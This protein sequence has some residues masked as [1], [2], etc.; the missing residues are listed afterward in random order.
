MFRRT[1]AVITILAAVLCFAVK[2]DAAGKNDNWLVYW[3]ICGADNLEG[4]AHFST[5]NISEL[6]EVNMPPNVRVLLLAGGT[7]VWNHPT[8]KEKGDGIYLYSANGL[9]KLADLEADM[10]NPDTLAQFLKYGE[11]NFPADHRILIFQD[12]GGH[13]GLCYDD[14]FAQEVKGDDGQTYKFYSFLTYDALKETFGAVY[15]KSPATKPF[16]LIGFNACMTGSYE[17]A[18]SIA[19]FSRYMMGSEPSSNPI[20]YDIV[21]MFDAL[22][23]NPAVDGAQLGKILCD[24]SLKRLAEFDKQY[25]YELAP[26]NAFS[27]IDLDKM[28]ELRTAYEAYFDEANRRAESDSGFSAAFA[29]AAESRNADRYSNTY[30]DLGLLAQN[31]QAIM[32]TASDKLLKAIQSA[33]VVNRRGDYLKGMGISTYYPYTST[34]DT[35]IS[36]DSY[37]FKNLFLEQNSNY[38]GQKELYKKIF[39]LDVAEPQE[40]SIP[41]AHDANGNFVAKLT[42]EQMKNFS[43]VEYVLL[44]VEENADATSV[45]V[46]GAVLISTDDLAVD[47]TTGI[48]TEKFRAVEPVFDGN[49]IWM[50][51]TV[52]G[53]GHTFYHVPILYNGEAMKLIVRYEIA[54]KKFNIV[55]FG[56]D[57]ENGM[58]RKKIGMPEVGA[59]ITPLYLVSVPKDEVADPSEIVSDYVDGNNGRQMAFV[60]VKG[61]PFTFTDKSTITARKIA[62]GNY[63]YAFNFN[64]PNGN[65]VNSDFGFIKIEGGKVTRFTAEDLG[66]QTEKDAA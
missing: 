18:N 19:D 46:G 56:S 37:E 62:D 52:N 54:A 12:H 64:A 30:T 14:K 7:H 66:L 2:V 44:P 47:W 1:I 22:A 21:D 16:E 51:P 26:V 55:G 9:E 60:V 49:R 65:D 42:P 58:V 13:S 34:D 17:L 35:I 63:I 25:D 32:P 36:T 20:G 33:V 24:G 43:A 28:P 50:F 11:E 27:V 23:K 45:D 61:E 6:Q 3:Y 5:M 8:I 29:R 4:E 41:L 48:V 40:D 59:E 10:G 15:G 57:V 31:T 53:R 38:R 39:S